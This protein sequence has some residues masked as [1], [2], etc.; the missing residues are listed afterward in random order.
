METGDENSVENLA[1]SAPEPKRVPIGGHTPSYVVREHAD[2]IVLEVHTTHRASR[3]AIQNHAED[4]AFFLEAVKWE[5]DIIR[6]QHYL[7]VA[8]L[9]YRRFFESGRFSVEFPQV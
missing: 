6:A 9:A 2:R 8:V 3:M 1:S 4:P 5:G 7:A